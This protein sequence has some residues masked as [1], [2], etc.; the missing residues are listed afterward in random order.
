MIQF[1]CRIRSIFNQND[2]LTITFS[3]G[4]LM[5]L[6]ISSPHKI[7]VRSVLWPN[8]KKVAIQVNGLSN[9]KTGAN[10]MPQLF[11]QCNGHIF[12]VASERIGIKSV[13]EYFIDKD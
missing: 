13:W 7:Y 1:L 2:L 6:N 4:T 12:D 9:A 11:T 3:S 5:F 8:G 10:E